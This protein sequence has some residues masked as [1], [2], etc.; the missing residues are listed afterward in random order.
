MLPVPRWNPQVHLQERAGVVEHGN[1]EPMRVLRV[2][3]AEQVSR[4]RELG[5][6]LTAIAGGVAAACTS[7]PRAA[8]TGPVPWATVQ[9]A[10][11]PRWRGT[12]G[13]KGKGVGEFDTPSG[14]AIAPDGT[15][16]V[17]DAGND[18]IA[19]INPDGVA[20]G[21]VGRSGRRPGALSF[22]AGVAIGAEG[23]AV[24][25]DS[26][27]GRIQVLMPVAGGLGHA[28]LGDDTPGH[29]AAPRALAISP[30]GTLLVA[31]S[32]H[33]RIEIGRAHV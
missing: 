12:V 2:S 18:R 32:Q 7:A 11:T 29:F 30:E 28:L 22:P 8:V 9:V 13:R 27:N 33:H 31:D 3:R 15:V 17:A 1:S 14:V 20:T 10:G 23:V 4:R 6:L 25:A 19:V 5:A 16:Y 21:T 26:G 24:V